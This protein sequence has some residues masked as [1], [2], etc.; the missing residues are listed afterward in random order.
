MTQQ[1]QQ[2]STSLAAQEADLSVEDLWLY[3][4][5]V[6]GTLKAFEF[7][8]YLHGV[9]PLPVRERNTIA[10]ALNELSSGLSGRRKAEVVYDEKQ[11]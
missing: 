7:G 2:H 10:F 8:A 4:Y 9:Y 6:G 11:E 3:Y 5:S 1:S